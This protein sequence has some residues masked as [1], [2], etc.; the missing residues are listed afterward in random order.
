MFWTS[1]KTE[2]IGGSQKDSDDNDQ[3]SK[4]HDLWGTKKKEL[5][6]F[7]SRKWRLRKDKA[8]SEYTKIYLKEKT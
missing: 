2:Q 6:L 5:V 3:S 1:G 7:S 8:I 4:K